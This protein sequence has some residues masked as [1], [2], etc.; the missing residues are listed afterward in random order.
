MELW[1]LLPLGIGLWLGLGLRFT[2]RRRWQADRERTLRL[3]GKS[4]RDHCR[5]C[6]FKWEDHPT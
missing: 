6:G 2:R 5:I 1:M 3:L 4:E